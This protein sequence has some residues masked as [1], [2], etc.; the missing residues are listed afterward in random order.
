VGETRP[1][2]GRVEVA[3][4]GF[5]DGTR[6]RVEALLRWRPSA[7]L[8]FSAEYIQNEVDV[9]DEHFHTR[10]AR[11]RMNV[12]F[13]PDLSWNTFAQYDNLTDT[14]GIN[15]RVRWIVTPGSELFLVFNQDL[16]ANDWDITRGRTEPV[17][18]L[19]WTF[20]F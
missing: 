9:T 13:T 20:R 1:L 15:S 14:I 3:Y 4:G 12:N 8:L 10:I 2:S 5:F 16:L 18:K 11:V 7:H 6:L 17:A 19:V